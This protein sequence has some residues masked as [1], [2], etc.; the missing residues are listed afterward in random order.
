M[1][2]RMCT[3]NCVRLW[4]SC[5]WHSHKIQKYSWWK[6]AKYKNN[7]KCQDYIK[8]LKQNISEDDRRLESSTLGNNDTISNSFLQGF[9]NTVQNQNEFQWKQKENTIFKE[10][11]SIKESLLKQQ[12]CRKNLEKYRVK[13][14]HILHYWGRSWNMAF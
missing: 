5:L 1:N 4:E 2:P 6:Y 7:S 8:K 10:E 14:C 11:I 9:R 13:L 12:Y 3:L